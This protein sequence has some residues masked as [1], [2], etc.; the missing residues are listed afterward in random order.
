VFATASIAAIAIC[1]NVLGFT[2]AFG[3]QNPIDFVEVTNCAALGVIFAITACIRI[4]ERHSAE[5]NNPDAQNSLLGALLSSFA[6]F[7][8]CLVAVASAATI[9][10]TLATAFGIAILMAVVAIRYLRFGPWGISAIAVTYLVALIAVIA[11]QPNLG[12]EDATLAFA[13]EAHAGLGAVTQRVLRDNPWTGIGAGTF[14]AI[15]PVYRDAGDT[16][17][18][19]TAT[20]AGATT[21]IEL[22]R[23]MFWAIV[24]TTLVAI[25]A[26]LR[27]ALRRGR[28]SYY[29][30]CGAGC[31]VTLLIFAFCNAGI[32]GTAISIIAVT[33]LGLAF[34]QSRSRAAPQPSPRPTGQAS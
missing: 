16:S 4:T 26:L 33:T 34:G 8:I 27:G 32:Y 25:I 31:F 18:Y 23:F 15:V 28:D 12:N 2:F 7:A 20:T 30:A 13:S 29:A 17:A 24:L 11:S 1:R 9:S 5:R 19:T 10:V 14:G 22:G 3:D 6:A 21:V